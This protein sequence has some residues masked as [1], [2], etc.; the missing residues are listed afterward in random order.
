MLIPDLDALFG[1][2]ILHILPASVHFAAVNTFTGILNL[3][4]LRS[5]Q[6]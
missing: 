4:P 5:G 3:K 6:E 2:F 1:P